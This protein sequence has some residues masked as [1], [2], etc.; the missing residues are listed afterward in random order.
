LLL[1][2]ESL[3]GINLEEQFNK[4]NFLTSGV[5]EAIVLYLNVMVTCL[6]I[7]KKVITAFVKALNEISKQ[8]D[9]ICLTASKLIKHLVTPKITA[10]TQ[11]SFLI[12][13]KEF[14]KSTD[15]LLV[16]KLE[17]YGRTIIT[18]LIVPIELYL[19]E[20]S[21]D[22]ASYNNILNKFQKDYANYKSNIQKLNATKEK[23]TQNIEKIKE[24]IQKTSDDPNNFSKYE[25]KLLGLRNEEEINNEAY[26]NFYKGQRKYLEDFLD[27]TR[28][29]TLAVKEKENHKLNEFKDNNL[30]VMKT[31]EKL[32]TQITEFLEF[33]NQIVCDKSTCLSCLKGV[34]NQLTP[35]QNAIQLPEDFF[36]NI[37]DSIANGQDIVV[38]NVYFL[39]KDEALAFKD[40]NITDILKEDE[41]KFFKDKLNFLKQN[42]M[43]ISMKNT[44]GNK[45]KYDGIFFIDE[46]EIVKSNYSCALSDKI[47]LQGKLYL[48]SKKVVFYSWFNNSTLF[49]KTLIEIPNDDIVSYNKK[50]NIIFDNELVIK[51]KTASFTFASFIGREKCLM[52]M[53]ELYT[54]ANLNA[55]ELNI[56]GDNVL[57]DES[58]DAKSCIQVPVTFDDPPVLPLIDRRSSTSPVLES[59]R[60][61]IKL[62][63]PVLNIIKPQ[64]DESQVNLI[65]QIVTLGNKLKDT[66]LLPRLSEITKLRL[67][68]FDNINKRKFLANFVNNRNVGELPLPFIYNSCYNPNINCPELGKD[69]SFVINYLEIPQNYNIVLNKLDEVNWPKLIPKYYSDKETSLSYFGTIEG[70]NDLISEF[71][72]ANYNQIEYKY[73]Y[74]HPILKKKFMGPS[75]L[76][77]DDH[78][79]IYF[80][81]P[82][83]LI[84][85]IFSN[86][87]G[88]MMM[89]TFYTV[90]QYRFETVISHDEITDSI[91][92][93][94]TMSAN[95]TV[96]F[97][98]DNWF[99]NKVIDHSIIDVREFIETVMLGC[100][101]KV[102]EKN[103]QQYKLMRENVKS[104]PRFLSDIS[105]VDTN[106]LQNILQAVVQPTEVQDGQQPQELLLIDSPVATFKQPEPKSIEL[107]SLQEDNE[108]A[109]IR[110]LGEF[111]QIAQSDRRIMISV[112]II[113]VIIVL[114]YF[115]MPMFILLVVNILGLL[116]IYNRL[117]QI[118]SRLSQIEKNK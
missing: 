31:Q 82:L 27:V 29:S 98:K 22:E 115:D 96:E 43:K 61:E 23:L 101:D 73:I 113:L 1:C 53:K 59:R 109:I 95:F 118:D 37:I 56:D 12:Q 46:D 16:K 84:V 60:R 36:N 21:F 91:K 63:Q 28:R 100:F 19:K 72:G 71:E 89:D 107:I 26:I 58:K 55:T 41:L 3:H 38:Q 76:D 57:I 117:S 80:I 111:V 87:S 85:E 25:S 79:K 75:K 17:E 94:T 93:N 105:F 88:Y 74:T 15:E 97:I 51:T 83:C 4:S 7:K 106:A 92:Y 49:G 112:F 40:F 8:Y 116:L 11:C 86:M 99:K 39:N 114:R 50:G 81:S 52:D 30:I 47:L 20:L 5:N 34:Y 10:L 65:G 14:A 66:S 77:V 54:N 32:F 42:Q 103:K 2:L 13:F 35:D 9:N 64:I 90:L 70:L 78:F 6:G 44:E 18:Q 62:D 33:K 108:M 69:K 102:F 110:M 68:T 24:N 67:N 104:K 48:T 45:K